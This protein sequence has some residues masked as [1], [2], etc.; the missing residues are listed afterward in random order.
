MDK[1]KF[2]PGLN[3]QKE[4]FAFKLQNGALLPF[5]HENELDVL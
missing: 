2:W 1:A 3:G 5:W 4:E